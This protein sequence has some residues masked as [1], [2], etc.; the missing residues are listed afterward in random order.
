M[1]QVT[2]ETLP[3][4]ET[5]VRR[6]TSRPPLTEHLSD[7]LSVRTKYRQ[8]RSSIKAEQSDSRTERCSCFV[9][10]VPRIAAKHH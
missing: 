8:T 2:R 7:H 9:R 6:N 3:P 4:G 1:G 5:A 10:A